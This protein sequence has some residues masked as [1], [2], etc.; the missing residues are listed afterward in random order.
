MRAAHAAGAPDLAASCPGCQAF[1]RAM[2]EV[3]EHAVQPH[4]SG[5]TAEQVNALNRGL[6]ARVL[7]KGGKELRVFIFFFFSFFFSVLPLTKT[8]TTKIPRTAL[9]STHTHTHTHKHTHLSSA[10]LEQIE[11]CEDVQD[12][13][14]LDHV[15][16]LMRHAPALL[17]EPLRSC[18]RFAL[19]DAVAGGGIAAAVTGAGGDLLLQTGAPGALASLGINAA[20]MEQQ[21]M[22]QGQ[23]M[24][25]QE[26]R[27]MDSLLSSQVQQKLL[28]AQE[29]NKNLREQLRHIQKEA[30]RNQPGHCDCCDGCLTP[31][32]DA[33]SADAAAAGGSAAHAA[34]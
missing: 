1:T 29:R 11:A 21:Q 19:P 8:T 12:M 28:A 14:G 34:H 7:G 20:A 27:E 26:M 6:C 25:E 9:A 22:L 30:Y 5:K 33:S 10:P 2:M 13:Y 32:Q 16:V 15:K 17:C 4:D 3:V 23:R 31:G 24:R 18:G